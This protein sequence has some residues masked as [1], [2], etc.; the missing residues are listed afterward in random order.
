[1]WKQAIGGVEGGMRL[2]WQGK[3]ECE[4]DTCQEVRG[5]IGKGD[6]IG[7]E[8]VLELIRPPIFSFSL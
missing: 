8:R 2:R 4:W 7:G 3:L 6:V 1:M 5:G